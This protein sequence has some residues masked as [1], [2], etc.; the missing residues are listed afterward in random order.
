[1]TVHGRG[2]QCRPLDHGGIDNLALPGLTSVKHGGEEADGEEHAPSSEVTHQIQRRQGRLGGADRGQGTGQG[3]VVDVVARPPRQ[4][5]V[6]APAGH[7]PVHE[8]SVPGETLSGADAE[9]LG[10]PGS[11]PFD[12]SVGP[13]HQPK[14]DTHSFFVLEVHPDRPLPAT[15]EVVSRRARV[16]ADDRIGSIHPHHIGAEVGKDHPAEGRRP[17]GGDLDNPHSLQGAGHGP[18]QPSGL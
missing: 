5:T 1:M 18:A 2:E 10:D 17:Q 8:G 9:T 12:Q 6:L 15:H 11:E 3:D 14:H 7:P 16:P 4:R 13:L